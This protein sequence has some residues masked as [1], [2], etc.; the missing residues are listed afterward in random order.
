[1]AI[2]GRIRCVQ[3]ALGFIPKTGLGLTNGMWP[4][5][6][7]LKYAPNSILSES[8]GVKTS[9]ANFPASAAALPAVAYFAI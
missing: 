5:L 7:R 2:L 8:V 6:V 3:T 9:R 1:L 4:A